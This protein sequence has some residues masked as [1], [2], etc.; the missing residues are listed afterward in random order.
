MSDE[1]NVPDYIVGGGEKKKV[2]RKPV[3]DRSR[4]R[5]VRTRRVKRAGGKRK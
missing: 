2:V 3:R 1:A 4:V 5:V